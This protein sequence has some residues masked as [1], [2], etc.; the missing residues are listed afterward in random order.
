MGWITAL[1]PTD[2]LKFLDIK[3]NSSSAD[4]SLGRH[5]HTCLFDLFVIPTDGL[6]FLDIK[7]NSSSA[8]SSLG[9]YLHTCLFD[10]FDIHWVSSLLSDTY[11]WQ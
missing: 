2:G 10:L 9:R 3:V 4:S 5:L 7:V 11:M 8:D 6:K 1:I